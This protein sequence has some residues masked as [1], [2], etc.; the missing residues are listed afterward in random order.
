M[1]CS[2]TCAETIRYQNGKYKIISLI[3]II[4]I[5]S[6]CMKYLNIQERIVKLSDVNVAEYFMCSKFHIFHDI[7]FKNFRSLKRCEKK[8]G[9][10]KPKTRKDICNI[11]D[12]DRVS[13]QNIYTILEI[14]TK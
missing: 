14:N 7:K 3:H 10:D 2:I 13:I 4:Q 5:N 6:M 8:N 12:W 1:D 9:K 11:Y